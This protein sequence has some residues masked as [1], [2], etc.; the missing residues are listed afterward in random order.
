MPERFIVP[1]FIDAEDKI[2]GPITV[3][4]FVIIL[5]GL[6]FGFIAYKLSDL[7][8]FIF[9]L[10]IIVLFVIITAFYKINGAPF[11]IF[12]INFIETTFKKPALRVWR[13]QHVKVEKFKSKEENEIKEGPVAPKK[14]ASSRKLSE[15]SL[16]IDTGGVYK[17]EK[18]ANEENN[19]SFSDKSV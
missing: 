12:A 18:M 10:V 4:Q 14:M 6:L 11:H 19:V 2:W 3:R 1:Q 17:G 16:I 13:K 9:W 15:L 8:L 7:T 5:V